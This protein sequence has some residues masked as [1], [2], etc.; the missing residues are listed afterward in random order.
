MRTTISKIFIVSAL[1]LTGCAEFK[2]NNEDRK[3]FLQREYN[4]KDVIYYQ[5]FQGTS[6]MWMAR[7]RSGEVL[8]VDIGYNERGMVVSSSQTL[9]QALRE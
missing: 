1:L 7:T 6:S 3:R 5:P 8:R 2:Y 9:F 4:T